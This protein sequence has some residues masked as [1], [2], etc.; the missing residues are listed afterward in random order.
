MKVNPVNRIPR[1]YD[2][3][4]NNLCRSFVSAAL[5]GG[6]PSQ[7]DL[8][9]GPTGAEWLIQ[10]SPEDQE[11]I[12]EWVRQELMGDHLTGREAQSFFRAIAEWNRDEATTIAHELWSTI[13]PDNPGELQWSIAWHFADSYDSQ[14]EKLLLDRFHFLINWLSDDL[15]VDSELREK[16]SQLAAAI[17]YAIASNS[18]ETGLRIL[19]DVAAFAFRN[20]SDDDLSFIRFLTKEWRRHSQPVAGNT[21]IAEEQ[22]GK[23][24]DTIDTLGP[25]YIKHLRQSAKRYSRENLQDPLR[26]KIL[27]LGSPTPQQLTRQLLD[28]INLRLR[29]LALVPDALRVVNDIEMEY[30]LTERAAEPR[31]HIENLHAPDKLSPQTLAEKVL[32]PIADTLDWRIPELYIVELTSRHEPN[33]SEDEFIIRFF[34]VDQA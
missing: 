30:V 31:Q 5:Y 22:L 26:S 7:G 8:S 9:C 16:G 4:H 12:K 34:I 20:N 28:N 13:P 11:W 18:F 27:R 1:N 21:L 19:P 33:R 6:G 23:I 3:Y 10:H 29:E 15:L 32:T 2:G 25:S 17:A 14:I 24:W